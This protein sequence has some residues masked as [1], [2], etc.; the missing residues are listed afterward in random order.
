MLRKA[1]LSLGK[2]TKLVN[3]R[4]S[5]PY[6]VLNVL[7]PYTNNY[8]F[9][10][11]PTKAQEHE[12]EIVVED[13]EDIS[14]DEESTGIK[15]QRSQRH[16]NEE[17]LQQEECKFVEA[18][19]KLLIK[20]HF[21][22]FELKG[23]LIPQEK[24]KNI[25]TLYYLRDGVPSNYVR[26][27]LKADPHC[28][29]IFEPSSHYPNMRAIYRS[30]QKKLYM[31]FYGT[32]KKPR[33]PFKNCKSNKEIFNLSRRIK[34]QIKSLLTRICIIVN[35][36]A[37]LRIR[38]ENVPY[39]DTLKSLLHP[40][41]TAKDDTKVG[42]YKHDYLIPVSYWQGIHS[43]DQWEKAGIPVEFLGGKKI[44]PLYSVWPPTNQHYLTLLND[45][46]EENKDIIK[47][48]KPIL[49]IGSGT[50][51]LSF[52]LVHKCGCKDIYA[53]DSNIKAVECTRYN[54]QILDVAG[55][56]KAFPMDLVQSVNEKKSEENL[57]KLK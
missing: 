37:S 5:L 43:S 18:G 33:N 16:F 47:A 1:F 28:L 35:Y 44:Y 14:D 48:K 6:P 41:K 15:K 8:Y 57:K 2:M 56:I 38:G 50:G 10:T 26:K 23:S 40:E 11:M 24:I 39:S 42:F 3:P 27:I 54:A 31:Q 25:K 9:S 29:V 19:D 34:I 7:F 17:T 45:Y 49:E 4:T 13:E 36:D 52:M 30:Y 51:V 20:S 32:K 53:I 55:A 21:G 46:L 12:N 22:L